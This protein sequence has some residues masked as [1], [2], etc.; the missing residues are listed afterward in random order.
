MCELLGLNFN[1]PVRCS[2]SFRGFRHRGDHNPHGWGIARFEGRASQVFKEPINAPSSKLATFL[3][4]YQ[5]FSSKIFIGHVRHATQGD[6]ALQNTH[7]FSQ[8]FRSRDVVLAHNGTVNQVIERSALKFH[9]V[10]ETDSEYLLCALLTRLSDEKISFTDFKSIEA[11]LHKFNESGTF[12]KRNT[13]NLL[14]SE[15]EHLYAYRD[16]QGYNGLCFTERA[17]PFKRVSL[18]DEDWEID[19]TEEKRP[20]QRGIVIATSPLTNET[21]ND[22]PPGSLHVFKDGGRVYG[23]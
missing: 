4:D 14:F 16:Q 19:L 9:P 13:M 1:Q 8:P 22:L 6:R 17:A 23:A 12:D 3:H 7:P 10:G 18:R 15:G 5:S 21:W 2:L 20:D 11:L